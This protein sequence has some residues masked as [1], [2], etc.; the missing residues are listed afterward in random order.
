MSNIPSATSSTKPATATGATSAST[1]MPTA[2]TAAAKATAAGNLS[3]NA[4]TSA[5][6]E[7][8][9]AAPLPMINNRPVL[10][11]PKQLQY[12][13]EALTA[14]LQLITNTASDTLLKNAG[15][16]IDGVAKQL[17]AENEKRASEDLKAQEAARKSQNQSFWSKLWGYVSKVATVIAAVALTAVTGGAAFGFA[18][19]MAT[20]AVVGLIKSILQDAGVKWADKIPTSIG[21][22]AAKIL[23][24][25]GVDE[26]TA[27]IVSMS[28]DILVA[29]AGLGIGAVGLRNAIKGVQSAAQKV[30]TQKR[31]LIGNA[32]STGGSAVAGASQI[33]MGVQNLKVADSTAQSQT[34]QANSKEIQV[35]VSKLQTLYSQLNDE[36]NVIMQGSQDLIQMVSGMMASQKQNLDQQAKNLV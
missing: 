18:V 27:G 22:I 3:A 32:L 23:V 31:L 19:V 24:A 2:S 17:K 28:V 25:A 1:A 13:G 11:A 21:D 34:A 14:L 15:V 16:A 33:G 12:S 7:T 6:P 4:S 30:M 29:V 26:K 8:P 9:S 20:T 5:R 36:I 10:E 35:A